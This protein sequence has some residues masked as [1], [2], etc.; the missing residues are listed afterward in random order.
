VEQKT[1]NNKTNTE[2]KEQCWRYH[3]TRLQIIQSHGNKNDHIDQWNTRPRNKLTSYSQ[4]IFGK[5]AKKHRLEKR[6]MVLE[7]LD[8]HM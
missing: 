6:Q 2:Q 8:I 4:L 7:K 5:G 1:P 3:N